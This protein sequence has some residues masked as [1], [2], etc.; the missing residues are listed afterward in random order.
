MIRSLALASLLV[1]I[2][3]AG[4]ASAPE[5]R[6]TPVAA[7]S[8]FFCSGMPKAKPASSKATPKAKAKKKASGETDTAPARVEVRAL[9]PAEGAEPKLPQQRIAIVAEA[10]PLRAIAPRLSE[11]LGLNVVL[12]PAIANKRVWLWMP[13]VTLQRLQRV[14]RD[15]FDISSDFSNGV[16]FLEADKRRA[17]R[18]ATPAPAPGPLEG[19]IATVGEKLDADQVAR[20]WCR[21]FATRRGSASVIDSTIV[22][23]DTTEGLARAEGLVRRLGGSSKPLVPAPKPESKPEP[24]PQVSQNP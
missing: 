15:E 24:G 9:A 2:G 14:L 18:K 17:R 6:A 4:C 8:S 5:V 11:A 13:D 7:R 19:R 10:A 1:P 23:E 20:T 12:D 3:L 22:F 21:M 16:L